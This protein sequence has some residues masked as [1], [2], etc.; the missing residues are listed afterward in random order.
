MHDTFVHEPGE[1]FWINTTHGQ[2]D[3]YDD[4]A[5]RRL[6]A[7]KEAV[8]PPITAERI[9]R[10]QEVERKAKAEPAPFEPVLLSSIDALGRPCRSSWTGWT[11]ASTRSSSAP[12][13]SARAP[14][15]RPGSPGSRAP[16]P[17]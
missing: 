15:R 8:S 3:L 14:W 16:R 9:V 5:M 4:E 7:Y 1:H 10:A 6:G 13:G 12:A 11:P 17:S 2:I